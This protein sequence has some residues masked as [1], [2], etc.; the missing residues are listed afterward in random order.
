[1]RRRSSCF[2]RMPRSLLSRISMILFNRSRT[3]FFLLV[4]LSCCSLT[5]AQDQQ[6]D[7]LPDTMISPE[8]EQTLVNCDDVTL[9]IG[10][11]IDNQTFKIREITQFQCFLPSSGKYIELL[12]VPSDF[13]KRW[14][15]AKEQEKTTIIVREDDAIVDEYTLTLPSE[16]FSLSEVTVQ[17][18]LFIQ[19]D[20]LPSNNFSSRTRTRNLATKNLGIN[21][22]LVFRI[23]VTFGSDTY[24][25]STTVDSIQSSIFGTGF[26]LATQYEACSYG[27]LKF[28][29]ADAS[30]HDSGGVIT[31]AVTPN[32]MLWSDIKKAVD[33]KANSNL[34]LTLSEYDHVMYDVPDG[35][36]YG[37][38]TAWFAFAGVVSVP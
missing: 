5:E 13:E 26:S 19:P 29:A 37:G 3:L 18:W 16:S 10:S 8:T 4:M 2:K 34:G 21:N 11:K 25:P 1:M 23:T 17:K 32:S 15:E 28:E 27:K 36:I 20:S 14:R 38:D 24:T 35:T 33:D 6:I 9:Q 7:T 22:I 30:P 31:I 12:N